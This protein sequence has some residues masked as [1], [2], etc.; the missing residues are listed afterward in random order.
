MRDLN[1]NPSVISSTNG[2]TKLVRG[3]LFIKTGTGAIRPYV[4]YSSD[5]ISRVEFLYTDGHPRDIANSLYHLYYEGGNLYKTDG[6]F[7][8]N[9]ASIPFA[10]R[11]RRARLGDLSI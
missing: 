5:Y 10:A 2:G 9:F 8:T 4:K 3:Q 11:R 6:S 1:F 7:V